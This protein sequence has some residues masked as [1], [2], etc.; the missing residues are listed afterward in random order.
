MYKTVTQLCVIHSNSM[1][2]TMASVMSMTQRRGVG[3]VQGLHVRRSVDVD[4]SD[5]YIQGSVNNGS[6]CYLHHYFEKVTSKKGVT[7]IQ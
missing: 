2:I 1:Q 5:K 3:D 7:Q 4:L 6:A